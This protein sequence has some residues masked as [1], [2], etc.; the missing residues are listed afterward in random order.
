[1]EEAEDE[2]GEMTKPVI[3]RSQVSRRLA[4]TI[5]DLCDVW[6]ISRAE[7]IRKGVI[8]ILERHGIAPVPESNTEEHQ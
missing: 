3:L 2:F 7:L 6:G 4:A 1:M 5:D 8:E